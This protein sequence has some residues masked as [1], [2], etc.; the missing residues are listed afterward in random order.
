MPFCSE[1]G[2]QIAGSVCSTCVDATGARGGSGRSGALAPVTIGLLRTPFQVL[3]LDYATLGCYSLFWAIRCR[4]LSELRLGYAPLP[5]WVSLT[6]VIPLWNVGLL[7]SSLNLTCR[8]TRAAGIHPPIPFGW[9]AAAALGVG[10]CC[11]LPSPYS[12][13]ACLS[14]IFI[15]TMQVSLLHAERADRLGPVQRLNAWEIGSAIAGLFI[16]ASATAD[17]L[18]R[19]GT[20]EAKITVFAVLSMMLVSLIVFA[21]LEQVRTPLRVR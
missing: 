5:Y 2:T 6:Y 21:R 9:Q 13:V 3:F 20:I 10:A 4:R 17:F 7:I 19:H 18:V 14:S 8:R 15:A 16:G 1:C 11:A 12:F